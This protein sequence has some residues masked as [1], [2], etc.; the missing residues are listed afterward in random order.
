MGGN[1]RIIFHFNDTLRLHNKPIVYFPDKNNYITNNY[2]IVDLD[3][4][5][6]DLVIALRDCECFNEM[7]TTDVFLSVSVPWQSSSRSFDLMHSSFLELDAQIDDGTR[8]PCILKKHS[9]PTITSF[10]EINGTTKVCPGDNLTF[11]CY[12]ADNDRSV[13]NLLLLENGKTIQN[14]G[15]SITPG[16][17]NL[18]KFLYSVNN[19]E[20]KKNYQIQAVIRDN[21]SLNCS[22]DVW[23]I[24]ILDD[25]M[26]PPPPNP[27][28]SP[29]NPPMSGDLAI[30][31]V[32]LF[33]LL[34]LNWYLMAPS[35]ISIIH[36]IF[37]QLIPRDLIFK[38][39][40]N[41]ILL[42]VF[43]CMN[44]MLNTSN[45]WTLL[46]LIISIIGIYV[47]I[48][49]NQNP[50]TYSNYQENIDRT[51]HISIIIII[52]SFIALVLDNTHSLIDP[53]VVLAENL[54]ISLIIPL[55][56]NIL[57]IK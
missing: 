3:K 57:R 15:Y 48:I 2:T 39:V 41:A 5:K 30:K 21:D 11:A 14:H 50:A 13:V 28:T 7:H 27:P 32:S 10:K 42:L 8:I 31:V 53:I 9:K 38:I 25:P 43:Y 12:F 34:M 55:C 49:L 56:L 17:P 24:S 22:S 54:S 18:Y 19:T 6:K 23:N 45:K 37:N 46:P 20:K 47:S 16:M 4:H 33:L 1:P 29:S 35:A 51:K 40:S 26:C 36:N 44:F 52:C